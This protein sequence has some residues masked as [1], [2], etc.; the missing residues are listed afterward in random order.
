MSKVAWTRTT[1]TVI[2]KMDALNGIRTSSVT[3]VVEIMEIAEELGL[4]VSEIRSEDEVS[5]F[6]RK[7]RRFMD[8]RWFGR[9][10]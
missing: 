1:K 8:S 10:N 3:E 6:N 2:F 7:A 9:T 5:R 4:D